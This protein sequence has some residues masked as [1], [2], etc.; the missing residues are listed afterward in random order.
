MYPEA[1]F[2]WYT[3]LGHTR[4]QVHCKELLLL[5]LFNLFL[6]F[7]T[8]S[9]LSC[10]STLTF[11]SFCDP[12]FFF[13]LSLSLSLVAGFPQSTHPSCRSGVT[14]I[15]G[16]WARFP[17][18]G[19]WTAWT[20]QDCWPRQNSAPETKATWERWAP[21]ARLV[22]FRRHMSLW[23]WP[24]QSLYLKICS[25]WDCRVGEKLDGRGRGSWK[26]S[27]LVSV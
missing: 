7:F 10:F 3:S 19:A 5:L 15:C 1:I 2:H 26:A 22:A 23:R 27:C 16:R 14:A 8:I 13:Y 21:S 12:F 9:F 11:F 4:C 24:Q 6:C 20:R 18:I 17:S 25:Q